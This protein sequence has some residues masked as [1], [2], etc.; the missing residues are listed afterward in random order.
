MTPVEQLRKDHAILR[1]KLEMLE[2]AMAVGPEAAFAIRELIYS[3]SRRLIEHEQREQVALYPVLHETLADAQDQ[4]ARSV[5]LEHE[6]FEYL[7][8]ALHLLTLRGGR[9]PLAKVTALTQ[10]LAGSLRS[11]MDREERLLFP[12]LERLTADREANVRAKEKPDMPLA[13]GEL[14]TINRIVGMYPETKSV[15][16]CHCIDCRREGGDFLDEVAW[17]HAVPTHDLIRELDQAARQARHN[18]EDA[19]PFIF[20]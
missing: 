14:M 1:A 4:F 15:F 12:V 6:E 17:R 2:N 10:E 8:Q 5:E 9:M 19:E 18:E 11:H 13:V 7:L 3:L 16:D 20:G